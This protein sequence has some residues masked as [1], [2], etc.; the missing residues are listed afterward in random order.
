MW[1]IDQ[2]NQQMYQQYA[3]AWDQGRICYS[4]MNEQHPGRALGAV[5]SWDCT[6]YKMMVRKYS[7]ARKVETAQ[8]REFCER[9][10]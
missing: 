7:T 6:L 3:S 4:P 9:L 1:P 5:R 8:F 2:N 10:R